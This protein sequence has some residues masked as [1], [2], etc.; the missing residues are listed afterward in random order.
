[1]PHQEAAPGHDDELP[2]SPGLLQGKQEKGQC[3]DSFLCSKMMPGPSHVDTQ[4]AKGV[5]SGHMNQTDKGNTFLSQ[6]RRKPYKIPSF[7][8]AL[9]LQGVRAPQKDA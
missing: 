7:R 9:M 5:I 3:E 6:E 1:M 8:P 4:Q 2:V